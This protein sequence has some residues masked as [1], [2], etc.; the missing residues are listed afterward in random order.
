MF[1]IHL[2]LIPNR[3]WNYI[4]VS[5]LEEHARKKMNVLRGDG[6]P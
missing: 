3:L 2:I 4:W 5:L 1:S 6:T